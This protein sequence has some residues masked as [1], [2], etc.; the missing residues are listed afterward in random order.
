MAKE[1][2]GGSLRTRKG[3]WMITNAGRSH[4][5][6][7]DLFANDG[8]MSFEDVEDLLFRLLEARGDIPPWLAGPYRTWRGISRCEQGVGP[9][10]LQGVGDHLRARIAAGEVWTEDGWKLPNA[11]TDGQVTQ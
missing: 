5:E 2:V 7:S 6:V 9:S 11:A 1:L 10:R 3:E 8:G 4:R